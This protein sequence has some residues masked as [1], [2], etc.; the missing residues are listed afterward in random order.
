MII[1]RV[2]GHPYAQEITERFLGERLGLTA[3]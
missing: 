2:T 1:E 3:T